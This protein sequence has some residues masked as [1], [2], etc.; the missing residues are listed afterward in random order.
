MPQEET[1]SLHIKGEHT[2]YSFAEWGELSSET[3][4]FVLSDLTG[5]KSDW[6]R[7][8]LP[9][10]FNHLGYAEVEPAA[11]AGW[12]GTPTFMIRSFSGGGMEE[13]KDA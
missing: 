4:C 9:Q 6:L 3:L 10:L 12:G 2:M 11:M 7:S 8:K 5:Y 1:Y 13:A